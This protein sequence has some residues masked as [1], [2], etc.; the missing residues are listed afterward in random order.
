VNAKLQV[1]TIGRSNRPIATFVEL[2]NERG[3]Q[4]LVDVRSFPTSRI[5]H[6][7]RE[8]MENGFPNPE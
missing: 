7:K 8:Q 5:E 1:W 3:I 2:L 6:F 4:A